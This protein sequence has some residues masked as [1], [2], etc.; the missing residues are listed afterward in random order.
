MLPWS[1]TSSATSSSR[2]VHTRDEISHFWD[3]LE[4]QL[5]PCDC[6]DEAKVNEALVCYLQIATESYHDYIV[7]DQD[8]YR[9]ALTIIKSEVF[10]SN[11]EFCI[12][13]MLSLV[14]I[15][16]LEMNM[17]FIICYIL[18]CHCK[19]DA[20]SLDYMLEYQG[21]TVIYNC[22]YSQFAYLDKYDVEDNG[23][24]RELPTEPVT[25]LD[26][27]IVED[28]K[29]ISTVLLD[30]LFQI[31]KYSKC[32]HSSLQKVDSFFVCYMMRTVRSDSLD[33]I[34]SNSK[35][36]VLLA[37][38][39]QYMISLQKE[40]LN[41]LVL[42][43]LLNDE[44]SRNFVELL[45]LQFNRVVDKPLQIMMCKLIYLVLSL[46]KETALHFFYVNDLHVFIDVL[47]RNLTNISEDEEGLR[48]TFLRVLYPLLKNTEWSS[49]YYRM[50]DLVKI[51]DHLSYLDNICQTN[52]VKPEH[53][54][55]SKLSLKC[56]NE[57][58]LMSQ[59]GQSEKTIRNKNDYSR[60]KLD[61]N[62]NLAYVELNK[63]RSPPAPP[64]PPQS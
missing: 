35:F 20:S 32:E 37:L 23:R 24:G 39:E 12:S 4:S 25:D 61:K 5:E 27:E 62:G 9:T 45:L 43:Y 22:L 34:F 36:R 16:T 7:N 52:E 46:D 58:K 40:D 1:P 31:L 55:T 50:E 13:K 57:I 33:D 3:Y 14:S 30:L 64:P 11:R 8:L 59:Q 18:L 47:I 26:L 44:I 2:H 54:V 17:K 42:E 10:E 51:L 21:F 63:R 19:S 6:T 28:F 15:E 56:L 48:N 53:L 38:N 29:K 41:N 60:R 49:T